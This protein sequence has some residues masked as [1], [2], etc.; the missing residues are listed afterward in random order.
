M[1][2]N[3]LTLPSSVFLGAEQYCHSSLTL[4]HVL[5]QARVGFSLCGNK[6]DNHLCLLCGRMVAPVPHQGY[7]RLDTAAPPHAANVCS[8]CTAWG[9]STGVRSSL[10]SRHQGWGKEGIT[11]RLHQALPV[12]RTQPVGPLPAAPGASCR[13]CPTAEGQRGAQLAPS[14]LPAQCLKG[15]RRTG[16]PPG[17][18]S[19]LP[20]SNSTT[21]IQDRRYGGKRVNKVNSGSKMLKT[22][23]YC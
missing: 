13:L 21:S 2:A 8:F 16:T 9:C 4:G 20:G 3:L 19:S 23:I 5:L 7:T 1:T 10:A 6:A 22:K 12:P 14:N 17:W 15:S 11:H 18:L